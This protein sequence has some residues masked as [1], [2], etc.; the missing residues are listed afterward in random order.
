MQ[1]QVNTDNATEGRAR[2]LEEVEATVRDHLSRFADRITT[3]EVHLSDTN[4][5]KGGQDKRCLIEVRP[6]GMEPLVTTDDA[7]DIDGSVTAAAHKM[8]TVLD[9]TFGKLD[10][11]KGR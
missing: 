1:V 5:D 9:R 4:G 6:S 7:G 2:L 3:V 11:R 10:S 8:V